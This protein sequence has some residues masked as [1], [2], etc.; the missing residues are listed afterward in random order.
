MKIKEAIIT[1]TGAA[2]AWVTVAVFLLCLGTSQVMM[3]AY[4][5]KKVLDICGVV[6]L[7][8]DRNQKIV[9]TSDDQRKFINELHRYRQKLGC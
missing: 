7:I 4:V 5:S 9:P 1:P 3:V 6:V 8:D 2:K